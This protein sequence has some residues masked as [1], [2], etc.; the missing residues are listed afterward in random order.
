MPM[1]TMTTFAI[2]V[3]LGAAWTVAPVM[4]ATTTEKI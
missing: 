3:A 4:A 1:K 2:A